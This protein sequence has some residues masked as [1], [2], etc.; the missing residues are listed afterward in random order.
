MYYFTN[1]IKKIMKRIKFTLMLVIMAS[2]SVFGYNEYQKRNMNDDEI[3]LLAN[4]EALTQDESLFPVMVRCGS[5]NL[6]SCVKKCPSCGHSVI[7]VNI[8]PGPAV[9]TKG[10]CD[11]GYV[12]LN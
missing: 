5:M 4:I 1:L 3:F 6:E 12:F 2:I 7:S 11:C 10:R 9:E 8:Y